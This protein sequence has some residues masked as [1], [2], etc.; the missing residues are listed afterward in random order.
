MTCNPTG[1]S[2]C[3]EPQDILPATGTG[4]AIHYQLARILNFLDE[5]HPA[6]PDKATLVTS[7]ARQARTQPTAQAICRLAEELDQQPF[8]LLRGTVK[9]LPGLVGKLQTHCRMLRRDEAALAAAPA[10]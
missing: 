6:D 7:L 4:P 9:P 2:G 5:Y 3:P 1:L 10:P 8:T